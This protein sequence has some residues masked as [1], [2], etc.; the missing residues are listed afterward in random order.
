M[1]LLY[2]YVCVCV[3]VCALQADKMLKP[4]DQTEPIV[5]KAQFNSQA[6]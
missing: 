4:V 3:C 1:Q 5:V 2:N 6:K